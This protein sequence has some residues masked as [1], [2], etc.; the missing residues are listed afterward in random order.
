MRVLLIYPETP[1]TF[2]S[3]RN[4]LKFISKKSSEP[5]LGL[6]TVAAMLPKSWGKKLIDL[7]VSR[8]NDEQLAWADYVFISGMNV[9]KQS[10]QEIVKRC[11]KLGVKVVAGGPMCTTEYKEFDG[12]DFFVLNEAEITLPIFLKDLENG[13]P[14]HVY[15]S[16]AFPDISST[17]IP[18]W[19]LLEKKKYASIGI[20]YS[21]GCPFNCEFCSITMLN[22]HKPRIKSKEQFIGELESLYQD[23]WRGSVFIVDD[24]FIGNKRKLKND[25]LPALIEWSKKRKHPFNFMTETSINLVDDDVLVQLM[26]E[27]GFH[28]AFIGIETPNE[29]SLSECGK[30]QNQHRDMVASVKKLQRCGLN[31]AGGFIVGFDNDPPNIFEQQIDFIQKSGIVTA[32]VGLLNAPSGTRLFKR[33]KSENRLLSVMSGDNMDGSMNFIPKMNYQKL[34]EGYKKIVTTIYSQKQY[35]KRVKTFLRE[36]KLQ[37]VQNKKLTFQEI[38][39]FFKSLWILG[40]LEKGKR[41]YWKLL[42]YSLFD[43]PKKFA[44]AVTMAIYGFHFRRIAETI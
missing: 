10:F 3:F 40:C 11:N 20:Q 5:P 17:P 9:H 1:S 41:Y 38:Q 43:C 27:A 36:Y 7:N 8:F 22:G 24:N 25:L 35:Y 23:G 2:W 6:L 18:L 13:N 26:V 14:K 42:F 19:G 33:M 34:K 12:V 16:D 29:E 21:R 32:M 28:S 4:A 31:I 15:K 30:S 44:L 39:A 37:K